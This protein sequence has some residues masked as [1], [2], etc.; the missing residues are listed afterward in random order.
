M[1]FIQ[2]ENPEEM[3]NWMAAR[4][5]EANANL[6]PEQLQITPGDYWAR[7][8]HMDTHVGI[9]FGHV[10]TEQEFKDSEIEAGATVEEADGGWRQAQARAADGFLYGRAWSRVARDGEYGSTHRAN[11]WPI[12]EALFHAVQAVGWRHE[13]LPLHE[14]INLS[15]S[16]EQWRQ[17]EMDLIAQARAALAEERK[18]L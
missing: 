17:H 10:Y 7:F 8:D 2:F 1:S 16:F 3:G 13:D 6:A 15:I 5:A 18:N 12:E 4:T 9:E 11:L 14:R